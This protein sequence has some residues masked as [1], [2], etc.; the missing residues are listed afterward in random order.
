VS[1]ISTG[2]VER[3]TAPEDEAAAVAVLYNYEKSFV[4]LPDEILRY[5]LSH[6]A[7]EIFKSKRSWGILFNTE[8]YVVLEYGLH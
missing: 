4:S 8:Y 5:S 6:T 3:E 2:Q 1:G 7:L